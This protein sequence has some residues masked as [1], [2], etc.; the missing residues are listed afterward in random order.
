MMMVTKYIDFLLHYTI[1][2]LLL[3]DQNFQ[4]KI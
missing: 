2:T 3:I 1:A 4:A